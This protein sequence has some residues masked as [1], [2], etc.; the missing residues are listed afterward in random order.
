MSAEADYLRGER[1]NLRE[2]VRLIEDLL[3]KREIWGSNLH[4]SQVCV[5]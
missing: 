4:I 2:T 5:R 3:A 1:D